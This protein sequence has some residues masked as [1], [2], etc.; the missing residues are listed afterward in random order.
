MAKKLSYEELARR[1]KAL[2]KEVAGCRRDERVLKKELS[3]LLKKSEKLRENEE[4]FKTIFENAS[5]EIIYLD[6]NG[7]IIEINDRCEELFGLKRN[8]VIGK[9]FFEFG[10]FDSTVMNSTVEN[11]KRIVNGKPS[12]LSKL[13]EFEIRRNDGKRVFVEVNPRVIEK[14]GKIKGI[15]SIIRDITDRKKMEGALRQYHEDLE[16][17]VKEHKISLGEANTALRVMLKREDE[18]KTEMEEK[19]LYNVMELVLPNLEKLKNRRMDARQK[20]YLEI[21]ES[22][23]NDIISPF[24]HNLSSRYFNFTSAELQMANLIKHGKTTK[25]IADML[26]LSINT[27]QFHRSNIRKKIG[28]K[29]KK[30]NL[31][32][33]LKSI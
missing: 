4:K 16:E 9:N 24:S 12:K 32:S 18:V 1:V 27:V 19:I 13:L 20:E 29:K 8:E 11:F 6:K 23:L 7:K 25:E 21:I 3:D 28:I 14:G 30:S 17:M 15:L 5:D 2:G 22:D 10:Y 26:N 31:S 33:Y